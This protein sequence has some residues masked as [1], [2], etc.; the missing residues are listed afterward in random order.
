MVINGCE[1]QKLGSAE[2]KS[3]RLPKPAF[4]PKSASNKIVPWHTRGHGTCPQHGPV[5]PTRTRVL[6]RKHRIMLP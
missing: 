6:M 3:W 2:A 4:L 5:S 1:D